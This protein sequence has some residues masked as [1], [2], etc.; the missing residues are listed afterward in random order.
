MIFYLCSLILLTFSIAAYPVWRF[1]L[2]IRLL[3]PLRN[4]V[5][6]L[7]QTV[8]T[9]ILFVCL[10]WCFTS[11][12]TIFQLC[13]GGSSWVEPILSKDKC[14]LFKDTTQCRTGVARARSLSVSS[15][16]LYHW[17]TVFPMKTQMKCRIMCDPF[18]SGYLQTGTLANSEDSDE[19]PH[20]VAF[21]QCLHCLQR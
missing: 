11:Q 9:Q 7:W 1:R 4:F 20:N 3:A 18:H 15:Q 5:C 19:M 16:A 14:V 6:D 21:H 13:Q 8:K 12:S 17:A 10:I 2:E